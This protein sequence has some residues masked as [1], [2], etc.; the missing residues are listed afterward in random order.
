MHIKYALSM[1]DGY[2]VL[3]LRT[4]ATW[5][6]ACDWLCSDRNKYCCYGLLSTVSCS[7]FMVD[8]QDPISTKLYFYSL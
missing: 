6:R 5:T 2:V 4:Y 8:K 1:R 7:G 3:Q